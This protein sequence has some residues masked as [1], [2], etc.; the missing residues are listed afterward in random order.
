[1]INFQSDQGQVTGG[2]YQSANFL[3]K[4]QRLQFAQSIIKNKKAYLHFKNVP[5]GHYAV[6][7][8]HDINQNGMMDYNWVGIPIEGYGFSNNAKPSLLGPPSG[9]EAEFLINN[10]DIA[11][12]ISINY[13]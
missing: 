12:T 8:L 7:L 5:A 11:I 3:D 13:W 9:K 10:Q 1:M 4:T 2:L 6:S